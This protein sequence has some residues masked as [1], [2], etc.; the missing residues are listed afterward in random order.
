MLPKIT[1]FG[2]FEGCKPTF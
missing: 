2:Y 1:N